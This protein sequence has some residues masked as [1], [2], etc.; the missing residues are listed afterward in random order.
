MIVNNRR[1]WSLEVKKEWSDKDFTISHDPVYIAV[2]CNN[3]LVPGT[4]SCIAHPSLTKRYFFDSLITGADFE[5]Y[6]VYEVE[7]DNPVVSEDG[8]L[9]S[10]SGIHKRIE[11]GGL[12]TIN[13]VPSSTNTPAPH[14]YS[15]TYHYGTSFK[16]NDT[17]ASVGN[18]K[19]FTLS[20]D[21]TLAVTNNLDAVIP[22][23]VFHTAVG[24]A[25]IILAAFCLLAIPVILKRTQKIKG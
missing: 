13:A 19:T 8:E 6:A 3:T 17:A 18:T 22:T 16:L 4:V 9:V 11:N 25:I 5:D 14:S 10:Y 2:Y 15:V 21:S 23:G 1:G 12:T 7:L 20:G 24:I